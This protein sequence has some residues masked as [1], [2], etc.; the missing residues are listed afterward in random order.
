VKNYGFHNTYQNC[1][2]DGA[3][4]HTVGFMQ[5]TNCFFNRAE[6]NDLTAFVYLIGENDTAWRF[7]TASIAGCTF[8]KTG[9]ENAES[10]DTGVMDELPAMQTYGNSF[11]YVTPF[12]NKTPK[13]NVPAPW[14]PYPVNTTGTDSGT[15]TVGNLVV[16]WGVHAESAADGYIYYPIQLKEVYFVGLTPLGGQLVH[17]P[18]P[19]DVYGNAFWINRT[20]GAAIRWCVIGRKN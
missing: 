6:E 7:D 1:Y 13:G 4:L 11:Y 16:M 8:R 17:Y 10:I 18:F 3:K 9:G 2:F 14:T 19:S 12:V 20:A 15:M 5:V